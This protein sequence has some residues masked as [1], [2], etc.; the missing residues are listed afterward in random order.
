MHLS[1][2]VH[3]V[4]GAEIAADQTL[5]TR[6]RNLIHTTTT[7]LHDTCLAVNTSSAGTIAPTELSNVVTRSQ[8]TGATDAKANENSTQT[9][10]DET[11]NLW[12]FANAAEFADVSVCETERQR[13]SGCSTA[14]R[15]P[16]P[17]MWTAIPRM[18][19]AI[20]QELIGRVTLDC[21]VL[22]ADT[23]SVAQS[24]PRF[25]C[26]DFELLILQS[27][28]QPTDSTLTLAKA[29]GFSATSP[30]CHVGAQADF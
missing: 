12:P 29:A 19:N 3:G 27:P 21:F 28:A 4:E 7:G 6:R 26:V 10:A 9:K 15:T 16:S 8:M 23:S 2:L 11:N 25:L 22:Q 1:K 30:L 14:C 20:T 5:D 18:I 24:T 17:R 13:L